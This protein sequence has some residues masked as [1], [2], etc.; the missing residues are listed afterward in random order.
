MAVSLKHQFTSPKVDGP[1][2]T[3]VQPSNWNAEHVLTQATNRLLGRTA[4]GTG[5]TDEISVG[6]NLVLAS[7]ELRLAD[8]VSIAS[9]TASGTINGG[10]LSTLAQAQA[11]AANDKLMTPVRTRDAMRAFGLAELTS[12]P[13][14]ANLDADAASGHYRTANTTTGVFPPGVS[15]T[16]G[17]VSVYRD[18]SDRIMQ[19]FATA[20]KANPELHMRKYDAGWGAWNTFS[21]TAP[22][23]VIYAAMD[24]APTGYLKANGAAVSRT[25]YA[26]LFGAIGTVFGAG[27]GS[28]TFNLPDLRGEFPRGWDDGRG[29]DTGRAFG[30]AQLD[31][32]QRITGFWR[33]ARGSRT[34]DIDAQGAFSWSTA[35]GDGASGV[36]GNHARF[37][38][39]S[40]NSPDA[41]V[42]ST[43]SGETRSRNVALLACI[44]F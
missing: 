7:G 11:G 14:L 34:V 2:A 37:D 29:V 10:I 28:T 16:T 22:G 27:N 23:T 35:G 24:T 15:P 30:S 4:A 6:N 8:S 25:T 43:T 19:V 20:N 21:Q 17:Y 13:L 5:P 12:A 32:M 39:D 33:N 1:D 40:A 3:L 41:R 18:A 42:S 26:A 38:F 44:K 36:S 31:Q 9:L